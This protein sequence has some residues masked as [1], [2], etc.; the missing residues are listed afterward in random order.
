MANLIACRIGSYG[1]FQARG[2]S[3]LPELGIRQVEIVLPAAGEKEDMKKRLADNGLSASSLQCK[4]DVSDENVATAM[5]AQLEVCA[6][7]GAKIAFV[8]AKAGETEPARVWERLRA[9]GDA[10]AA[11]G[12]TVVLETH[13][14]LVTNGS[15]GRETMA[16]VDHPN[17]RVNFDTANVYYYNHDV[18]TAGEL[19]KVITYVASVHLKDTN[20]GFEDFHFPT[21][22]TG[23]VDFPEV[24]RQLGERGFTGPYTMELEGIRG[25]EYDEAGRLQYVADSVAYLREIGAFAE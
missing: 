15:V 7:F 9:V 3:H 24:F 14:D 19:E 22:G 6:E 17:I 23:V 4:C 1:K 12:V 21:L 10:A 13:P 16:A 5:R 18:T 11:Y 8:S 25:V 20:G 2:W